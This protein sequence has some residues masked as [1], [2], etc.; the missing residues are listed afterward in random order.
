MSEDDS[1]TEFILKRTHSGGVAV[2]DTILH[3]GAEDA[4]FGGIGESGLGHYHGKE[5]F[6]TFSHARTVFK[7]PTWL[8]RATYMLKARKLTLKMIRKLFVK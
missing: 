1:S 5:G 8:P 6:L 4:P 2:N 3:V 7:T